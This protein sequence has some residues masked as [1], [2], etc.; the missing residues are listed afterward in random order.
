[1]LCAAT[2]ASGALTWLSWENALIS[3]ALMVLTAL[4]GFAGMVLAYRLVLRPVMLRVGPDGIYL[5]RLGVTVPWE[6][7][8]RIER[9]TWHQKEELF[10]LVEAESQHPVFDE[11]S[12]LLGAAMNQKIGLPPLAIQMAQYS[13]T[14]DDFEAAVRAAGGPEIVLRD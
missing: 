6:A 5:K 3:G 4:L 12:L 14:A 2:L 8:E 10:E 7:I 11:R 9:F 1:M 13:G